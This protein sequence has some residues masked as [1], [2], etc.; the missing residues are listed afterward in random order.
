MASV[1]G[2]SS[3]A[4]YSRSPLPMKAKPAPLRTTMDAGSIMKGGSM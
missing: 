2:R 4:S 1:R 3:S